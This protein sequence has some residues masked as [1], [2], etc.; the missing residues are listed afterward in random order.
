MLQLLGVPEQQAAQLLADYRHAGLSQADQALL[1]LRGKVSC[2]RP[3]H[4]ASKIVAGLGAHGF[5]DEA[6]LE[7]ILVTA[8]ANFLCTLSTGLGAEPD[9]ESPEIPSQ[10]R[11]GKCKL[12]I[13]LRPDSGPFQKTGPE[14]ATA[15]AFF[16][17]E[18]GFVPNLFRAQTLHPE[19]LAAEV[20][21]VRAIL[22]IEDLLSRVQ[23]E[24]IL[25]VVSA[26]NCN[27]YCVAVHS[28]ILGTLGFS[29]RTCRPDR[30]G[31]PS[32]RP[33]RVGPGFIGLCT[34]ACRCNLPNLAGA[35]L[36][37]YGRM[38]SETSRFWKP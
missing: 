6:L 37:R 28:E 34:K 26:A 22:L 3:L 10:A 24:R 23:K 38:A 4:F 12:L 20:G 13:P 2:R 5:T 36:N 7:A 33:L 14:D 29:V 9:F 30:A 17:E 15:L 35:T 27:T 21:I 19:A 31:P 25:L 11:I 8:W 32:G 18:F 16:R 1:G